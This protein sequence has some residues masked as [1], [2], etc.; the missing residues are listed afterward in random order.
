MNVVLAPSAE[1]DLMEACAYAAGRS[2]GSGKR[3]L[4]RFA[5]VV[6]LLE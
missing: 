5:A 1:Q 2:P 6:E 4:D 3:L